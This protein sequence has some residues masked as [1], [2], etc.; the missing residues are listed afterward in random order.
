MA[1]NPVNPNGQTTQSA[2]APVVLSSDYA[3]TAKIQAS[4]ATTSAVPTTAVPVGYQ[5]RTTDVTAT[6]STYNT[7]AIVDKA[8]KQ[9]QLPYAIPE[10]FTKGS[11]SAAG[12]SLTNLIVAAGAGVK[13]YITSISVMN[14]SSTVTTLVNIQD[15]SSTIYQ[16]GAPALGGAIV[17]LPVP[18][19]SS[20]NTAINFAVV[21]AASTIYVSVAGYTGA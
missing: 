16:V 17:T 14:T 20:A 15:G 12:T 11:G 13:I 7:I 8:G 1:Y 9:V 3:S 4:N 10:L 18:I 5:A 6:T 2:S 21:N 19:A